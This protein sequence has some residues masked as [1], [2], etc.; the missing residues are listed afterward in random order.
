MTVLVS[1]AESN[2]AT[3]FK[4]SYGQCLC[5]LQK[6]KTRD[7]AKDSSHAAIIKSVNAMPS[8]KLSTGLVSAINDSRRDKA[9]KKRAS[10][11]PKTIIPNQSMEP[12]APL[13]TTTDTFD[14]AI[15]EHNLDYQDDFD[16]YT[17]WL[18]NLWRNQTTYPGSING[19]SMRADYLHSL[20]N[21]TITALALTLTP[22]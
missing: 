18:W 13:T 7:K 19:L 4:R 8:K 5:H 2:W 12:S 11:S 10:S 1:L 16:D 20:R 14:T 9:I 3:V 15:D 6:S 21:S 17:R 22:F